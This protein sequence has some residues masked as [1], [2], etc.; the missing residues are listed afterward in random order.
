MNTYVKGHT[1]PAQQFTSRSACY[2]W[3]PRGKDNS[4]RNFKERR[5]Y[6]GHSPLSG[7]CPDKNECAELKKDLEDGDDAERDAVLDRLKGNILEMAFH[8]DG[9]RIVQL[10]F[11]VGNSEKASQLVEE[12]HGNVRILIASPHGNHVVQKAITCL[13]Q[14][15]WNFIAA[16]LAGHAVAVAKDNFGCRVARDICNFCTTTEATAALVDEISACAPEMIKHENGHY[17]IQSILEHGTPEQRHRVAIELLVNPAQFVKNKGASFVLQ[18]AL[19]HCSEADQ[20]AMIQS[21]LTCFEEDERLAS[22]PR[23]VHVLGTALKVQAWQQTVAT[24]RLQRLA[25]ALSQ[26]KL[27]Q[28]RM[29]KEDNRDEVLLAAIDVFTVQ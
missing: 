23:G 4:K 1:E 7:S 15:D 14:K 29:K 3:M 21:L 19:D 27:L 25:T 22:N 5:P 6:G 10:A 12:L 13:K 26:S 17:A 18:T 8:P 28:R 11:R 16:E 2:S 20:T 24:D 9:C